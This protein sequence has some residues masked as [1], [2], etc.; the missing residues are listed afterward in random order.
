M[1]KTIKLCDNCEQEIKGVPTIKIDDDTCGECG[2][3]IIIEDVH[4]RLLDK[5]FCGMACFTEYL[6]RQKKE[7]EKR[8][9]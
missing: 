7:I 4:V 9:G 2:V 8:K 1:T 5:D 3:Y 6:L